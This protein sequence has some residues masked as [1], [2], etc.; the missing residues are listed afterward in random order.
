M[1]ASLIIGALF[2]G[3]T[4]LGEPH[5]KQLLSRVLPEDFELSKTEWRVASFA[6]ALFLAALIMLL[7]GGRIAAPALI[8]G[9][10]LGFFAGRI[11]ELISQRR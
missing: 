8:L 6:S 2:G 10:A 7:L 1:L 4:R 11:G 3:L 5:L 9:G